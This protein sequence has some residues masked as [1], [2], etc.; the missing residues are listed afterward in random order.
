MIRYTNEQYR[1][2]DE[3]SQVFSPSAPIDDWGLFTGRTEQTRDLLIS[4]RQKGQ[5]VILYGERGVGK[6]SLTNMIQ[7]IV[8]S[9]TSAN[10]NFINVNCDPTDNFTSL[11]NKAF[12]QVSVLRR[13]RGMGFGRSETLT[14]RSLSTLVPSELKPDDIRVILG[15]LPEPVTFII[16]EI[17][18]LV[19]D[20][21]MPLMAHTIK[22]LS[23]YAV[24]SKII[25]VGV[26]DTVED[27]VKEHRSIERSLVQVRMPRMSRNELFEVIN[28]ALVKV[29]IEIDPDAKQVIAH[30]SHGLPHYT[31][32]LGLFSAI[33]A[34]ETDSSK[35][36]LAHVYEATERAI[37]KSAKNDRMLQTTFDKATRKSGKNTLHSKVLLACALAESDEMGTFCAADVKDPLA[38]ITGRKYGPASYQR[39]LDDFAGN[40]RGPVLKKLGE[41]GMYRYRFINPMLP[42]FAVIKGIH[43]KSLKG[44]ALEEFVLS[45]SMSPLRKDEERTPGAVYASSGQAVGS[46][47]DG[48][49]LRS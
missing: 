39:H 26:A 27:L 48:K 30:L 41:A 15:D 36:T 44:E 24:K 14:E 19:D 25:L 12:R 38:G 34:I 8:K 17:D 47:P 16:D 6:T 18:T 32:S 46:A 45:C 37:E 2:M 5:H 13:S 49:D 22:G 3:V 20:L 40:R 1:R 9:K 35:I 4:L 10:F 23:D 7:M 29:S 21:A 33:R 43:E 31:H 28:R 42:P 11:W